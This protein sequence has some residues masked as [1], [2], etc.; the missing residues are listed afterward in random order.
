MGSLCKSLYTRDWYLFQPPECA[1]HLNLRGLTNPSL[2]CSARQCC[3]LDLRWLE[4]SKQATLRSKRSATSLCAA[5]FCCRCWNHILHSFH[6]HSGKTAHQQTMYPILCKSKSS[7][8]SI[9]YIYDHL[10][11]HAVKHELR[12]SQV[13]VSSESSFR[14]LFPDCNLQKA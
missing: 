1:A 13:E 7:A 12:W 6:D 2:L 5:P 8:I 3:L 11:I 14:L 4:T 9:I 10:C